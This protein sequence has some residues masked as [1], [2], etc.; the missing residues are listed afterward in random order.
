MTNTC[1]LA[2]GNVGG[3]NTITAWSFTNNDNKGLRSIIIA[4]SKM[5]GLGSGPVSN[6]AANILYTTYGKIC[7]VSGG[8][9]DHLSDQILNTSEFALYT[10]VRAIIQTCCNDK[11]SGRTDAQISTDIQTM[12]TAM[13]ATGSI[14][15]VMTPTPENVLDLS[16]LATKIRTDY[17]TCYIDAYAA[18]LGSGTAP[19]PNLVVAD[20]VHPSAAG[21]LVIAALLNSYIN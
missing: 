19:D 11:R 13:E 10:P 12:K 17:P 21:H 14:V 3:D 18:L 6:R 15:Y 9:S 2:I 8:P 20:G 5:S 16:S 7:A 1:R 4:D